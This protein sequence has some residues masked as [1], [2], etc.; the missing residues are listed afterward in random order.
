MNK[1]KKTRAKKASSMATAQKPSKATNRKET[2]TVSYAAG[3]FLDKRGGMVP[4]VRL[5]RRASTQ[6]L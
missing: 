2:K 5:G 6:A 3:S 1:P 4:T